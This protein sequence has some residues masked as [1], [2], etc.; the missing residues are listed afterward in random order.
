MP[1]IETTSDDHVWTVVTPNGEVAFDFFELASAFLKSGG[2]SK[3]AGLDPAMRDSLIMAA[4]EVAR[5]GAD[6]TDHQ[7][8]AAA[9]RV[10]QAIEKQG[11]G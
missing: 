4:R 9:M 2:W 7:M 1:K 5:G 3:D 6:L 8:F 11:K 10:M